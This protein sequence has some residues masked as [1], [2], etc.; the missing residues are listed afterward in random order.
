MLQIAIELFKKGAAVDMAYV[1]YPGGAASVSAL[2]A[3]EI[4]AVFVNLSEILPKVVSGEARIVMTMSPERL[5][6]A[7]EAPTARELG[8]GFDITGWF[9]VIAPA[10]T[11]RAEIARLQALFAAALARPEIAAR[12]DAFNLVRI[13]DCD[14][15]A[16]AFLAQQDRLIGDIIEASDIKVE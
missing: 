15:K 1:P 13:G 3:S 16:A 5:K 4:S 8:Y 2:M 6:A 12:I 11:P 10:R 9:A 14:Q 7:P